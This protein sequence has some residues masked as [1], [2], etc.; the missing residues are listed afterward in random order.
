MTT[1]AHLLARYHVLAKKQFGQDEE[2]RRAHLERHTGQRSAADCTDAQLTAV[3]NAM[4]A[5]QDSA[6]GGIGLDRPTKPQWAR[7]AALSRARG[8]DGL[9][10][11][12]LKGFIR[13]TAKVA[14]AR[15]L[16]RELISKVIMGLENWADS[17]DKTA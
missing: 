13:R 8:W 6:I 17:P 16:T 7:L 10:D 14:A 2:T 1:R 12:R 11:A 3:A 4:A 9:D 5:E 15:F